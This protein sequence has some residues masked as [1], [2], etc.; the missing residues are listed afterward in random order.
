MRVWLKAALILIAVWLVAGAVI[1]FSRSAR[2]TADSLVRHTAANSLEGLAPDRRAALIADVADRLNRLDFEE[3]QEL[4]RQQ[5]DREFFR[6]LTPDER[7]AFLEATLPEGFRQL[8]LGLNKM[9]PEQ[10]RKIVKRALDDLEE[11]GAGVPQR[12]SDADAKR[13]VEEGI[14]A[15]YE[16]ASAEVKLDFAPVIE[17]LQRRVQGLR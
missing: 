2:P 5:W 9:D 3:R 17:Q 8:M 13:V 11:D 10:R 6:A 14:G 1:F 7:R 15:F 12:I 4:R 16:D